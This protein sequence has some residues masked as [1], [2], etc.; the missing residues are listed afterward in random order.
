MAAMANNDFGIRCQHIHL[1]PFNF[2]LVCPDCRLWRQLQSE[3]Q[4]KGQPIKNS[5][6][7]NKKVKQLERKQKKYG[8]L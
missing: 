7:A 2:H 8:S 6:K 4:Q 3:N 5:K 1:S